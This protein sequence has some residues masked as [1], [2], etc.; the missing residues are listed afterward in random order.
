MARAG[1]ATILLAIVA[2]ST[3]PTGVCRPQH[4]TPGYSVEQRLVN[5][6][7][8]VTDGRGSFRPDLDR[9]D[10][11]VYEDGTQRE[12]IAFSREHSLPLTLGVLFE[13]KEVTA[14]FLETSR[15]LAVAFLRETLRPDDRVFLLA[16]RPDTRLLLDETG[17]VQSVESLFANLERSVQSAPV[18]R[19]GWSYKILDDMALA[20]E[21][22]LAASRGRKAILLIQAGW[23]WRS[24]TRS[25]DLIEKLQSADAIVYHLKIPE[26]LD[27]MRYVNPVIAPLDLLFIRRPMSRICAETGG[28]QFNDKKFAEAFRTIER[29]L[30]SNYTIAFRPGRTDPDGNFHRIAIR[31]RQPDMRVRHRPGYRDTAR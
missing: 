4:D 17:S 26:T 11:E 6:T 15:R 28:R 5:V 10:F 14:A 1:A 2:G 29:E 8:T 12:I 7:F 23:D 13:A 21:R 3:G 16:I 19:S 24:K 9:N 20:V 31:T 25:A 22:K 18:W 30:R 27:K